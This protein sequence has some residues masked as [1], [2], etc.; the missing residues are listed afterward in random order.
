MTKSANS[1]SSE[2]RLI[3]NIAFPPKKSYYINTTEP[4][5]SHA[6]VTTDCLN[7]TLFQEDTGEGV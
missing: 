5:D 4:H 1:I 7:L 6:A 3:S 2:A